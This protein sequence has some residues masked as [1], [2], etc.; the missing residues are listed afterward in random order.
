[1]KK[2]KK[3]KLYSREIGQHYQARKGWERLKAKRE[4][5]IRG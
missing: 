1:M 4:G 3:E 2:W 5:G